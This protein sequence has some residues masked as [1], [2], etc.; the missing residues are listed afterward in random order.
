MRR[1]R[2]SGMLALSVSEL[3][4]A[5]EV[6]VSLRRLFA[7]ESHAHRL[8]SDALDR[9]RINRESI[10]LGSD[11]RRFGRSPS[12]H[13]LRTGRGN[14][15]PADETAALRNQAVLSA[16]AADDAQRAARQRA[17]LA[18]I[19]ALHDHQPQPERQTR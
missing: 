16:I 3:S 12:A 11:S 9:R 13:S 8:V 4:A 19:A 2:R 10:A 14:P 17:E 7:G 5:E 18:L 6:S 15:E 1:C